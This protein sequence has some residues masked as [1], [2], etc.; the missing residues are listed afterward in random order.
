MESRCV[1]TDW[2][3]ATQLFEAREVSVE[4]KHAADVGKD[5]TLILSVG[6]QMGIPVTD[7]VTNPVKYAACAKIMGVA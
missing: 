3:H 6:I 5:A 7:T 2:H 4:L 1:Y